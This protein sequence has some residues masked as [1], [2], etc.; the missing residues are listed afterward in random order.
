MTENQQDTQAPKVAQPKKLVGK[1]SIGLSVVAVVV[2]VLI[3]LGGGYFYLQSQLRQSFDEVNRF[4][5]QASP[6]SS[7]T[8]G[9]MRADVIG[10]QLWLYDF[11]IIYQQK[12]L[13]TIAK[14]G[15]SN[16][17]SERE[18]QI[19][20]RAQATDFVLHTEGLMRT[21]QGSRTDNLPKAFDKKLAKSF[22]FQNLELATVN[23]QAIIDIPARYFEFRNFESVSADR[24]GLL[25]RQQVTFDQLLLDYR[26]SENDVDGNLKLRRLAVV[27]EGKEVQDYNDLELSYYAS[28]QPLRFGLGD[29]V[30]TEI[31]VDNPFEE[32][33]L[34]HFD[35]L[36]IDLG[37]YG[38]NF[39]EQKFAEFLNAENLDRE[40][41]LPPIN[42]FGVHLE[43]YRLNLQNA[44]AM[45]ILEAAGYGNLSLDLDQRYDWREETSSM[46][47]MID[48][49]LKDFGKTDF[50]ITLGNLPAVGEDTEQQLL[51][52]PPTLSSAKLRIVDQPGRSRV[53]DAV[54]K[55]SEIQF[56][57][58]L[59]VPL[60][61]Q[62]V[63]GYFAS[64]EDPEVRAQIEAITTFLRD[65]GQLTLSVAPS[66]PV[67]VLDLMDI[68]SLDPTEVAKF[69]NLKA[70]YQ[71][72]SLS[73][74]E[75]SIPSIQAPSPFTRE[76]TESGAAPSGILPGGDSGESQLPGT[77]GDQ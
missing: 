48:A 22:I 6:G 44:D 32:K 39:T 34:V 3:L 5:A 70:E 12:P 16:I 54:E 46:D 77:T 68:P 29:F 50:H 71:D 51:L 45:R 72:R 43:G 19:R 30:I 74:L 26:T 4:I 61:V 75:V 63:K 1:R 56:Q 15:F 7:V 52:N 23:T 67:P 17:E 47:L 69:M 8:Y 73:D 60:Y 58:R 37:S 66:E 41:A 28:L 57:P 24:S 64:V 9:E 31:D 13:L 53:F 65:G 62:F 55:D 20:F 21:A 42:T 35:D 18:K 27:Q 59:M 33:M 76:G 10:N 49:G 14:L 40:I 38:E 25:S 11:K 36:Y 2:L